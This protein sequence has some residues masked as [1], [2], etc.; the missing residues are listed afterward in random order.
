MTNPR[1][2]L[3]YARIVLVVG[4]LAGAGYIASR[5][6][7]I[8]LPSEGCS[9]V[10]RFAAGDRLLVDAKPRPLQ[11]RDAVLVRAEGG[12]LQLTLIER[13]RDE[14]GALWCRG[15]NADCP[16]FGSEAVGWVP[17]SS[18]AGRVLLGWTL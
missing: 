3:R 4:A 15:D 13:V 7:L 9:P 1:G 10:S 12:A 5:F 6:T 8:T 17:R 14:D 18:V 11:P 16:G 2:L